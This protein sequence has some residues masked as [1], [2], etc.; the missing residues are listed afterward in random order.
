MQKCHVE[1]IVLGLTPISS[2]Q[3]YHDLYQKIPYLRE[4][5]TELAPLMDE[6]DPYEPVNFKLHYLRIC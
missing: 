2:A 3:V 5:V 1:M 6:L 4:R